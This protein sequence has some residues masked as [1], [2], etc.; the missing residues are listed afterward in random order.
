MAIVMDNGT[1]NDDE[2]AIISSISGLIA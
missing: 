2:A 1:P